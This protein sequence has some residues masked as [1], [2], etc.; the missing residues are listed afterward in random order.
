MRS[1]QHAGDRPDLPC[2]TTVA[3]IVDLVEPMGDLDR[4]AIDDLTPE[5]ADEYFR[6]LDEA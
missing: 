3:E 6:I 2:P 5:E 1:D 4:F